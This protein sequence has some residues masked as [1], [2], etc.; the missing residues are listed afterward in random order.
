MKRYKN[1][2]RDSGVVAYDIG[3]ESISVQFTDGCVYLY[4]Y[5]SAGSTNVEHMKSLAISGQGLSSFISQAVKKQFAS[6]KC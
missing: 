3:N 1:L 6:K 4:T 5:H 2:S